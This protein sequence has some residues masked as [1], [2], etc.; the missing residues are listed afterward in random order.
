MGRANEDIERTLSNLIT[1]YMIIEA[2][3][4]KKEAPESVRE[5]RERICDLARRVATESPAP[6]STVQVIY[7]LQ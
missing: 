3:L 2:H 6:S 4:A 1:D 5:A 7:I